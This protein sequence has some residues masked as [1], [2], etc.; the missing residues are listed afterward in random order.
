MVRGITRAHV[1]TWAARRAKETAARTFNQER[2]VLSRVFVY[3]MR[4]G[5]VLDNPVEVVKR[6]KPARDQIVIPTKEQFTTLIRTI[7]GMSAMAMTAGTCANFWR[8][9]DVA[10]AKQ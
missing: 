4:D 5:V 2:A 1:E 8:T 3:A 6:M 10:W 7:E 9:V